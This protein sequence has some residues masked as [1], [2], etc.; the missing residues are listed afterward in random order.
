[1][2]K[3]IKFNNN[4]PKLHG[5]REAKLLMAINEFPEKLLRTKYEALC[6]Y[7]T[8][9]D[10]GKYY[11]SWRAGENFI[12]LLFLGDKNILFT[13]LRKDNEENRELYNSSIGDVF[14]IVVEG[15]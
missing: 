15:E 12:L 6:L 10:D 14:K 4:Y 11:Q 3:T 2:C 5:Q 7:D 13:T 9:R 1:M 8:I